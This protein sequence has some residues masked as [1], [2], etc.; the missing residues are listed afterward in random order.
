VIRQRQQQWQLLQR[1]ALPDALDPKHLERIGAPQAPRLA[2]GSGMSGTPVSAGKARGPAWIWQEA[3]PIPDVPQGFVLVCATLDTGLTPL[4]FRAAAV[5]VERGG[6]LSHGAIVARQ[7]GIPALVLADAS[8]LLRDGQTLFV[9][10]DRGQ[11]F[12][13]G[14]AEP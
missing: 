8:R 13:E 3:R 7:L 9:D 2:S 12:C 11:I 6:L 14:D 1:L 4:L 5:V 10:G